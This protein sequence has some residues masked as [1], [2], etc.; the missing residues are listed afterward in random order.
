[1]NWYRY[2][3]PP[4]TTGT[5]IPAAFLCGIVAAV[6]IARGGHKA[7]KTAEVE[8]RLRKALAQGR[9]SRAESNNVYARRAGLVGIIPMPGSEDE[10]GGE[11]NAGHDPKEG[12]N[13]RTSPA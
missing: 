9:A 7:K 12:G 2:N 3:R 11:G 6:L 8:E 4:W 10:V 5:L 13:D 1:M